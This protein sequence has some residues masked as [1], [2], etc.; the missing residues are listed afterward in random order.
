M[1]LAHSPGL[2]SSVM[3]TGRFV[4]IPGEVTSGLRMRSLGVLC[5]QSWGSCCALSW[6]DKI[7]ICPTYHPG[8]RRQQKDG[9]LS[10]LGD[11][12][13]LLEFGASGQRGGNTGQSAKGEVRER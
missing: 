9:V 5:P 2:L 13:Q 11:G 12:G 3:A 8:I 7:T 4:G 1:G 6:L 10:L